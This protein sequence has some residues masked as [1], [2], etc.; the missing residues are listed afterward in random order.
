MFNL[1][2][3]AALIALFFGVW[4]ALLAYVGIHL[5]RLL[6]IIAPSQRSKS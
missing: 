2:G 4:W 1:V 5:I 6:N 3:M